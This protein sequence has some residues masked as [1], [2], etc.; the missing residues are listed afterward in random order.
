MAKISQLNQEGGGSGMTEEMEK[1]EH[2]FKEVHMY[3]NTFSC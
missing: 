2:E 1:K 3:M